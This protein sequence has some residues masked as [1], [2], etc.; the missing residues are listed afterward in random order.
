MDNEFTGMKKN[1][2][3]IKNKNARNKKKK[4]GQI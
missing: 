1:E 2:K 4:C 3:L